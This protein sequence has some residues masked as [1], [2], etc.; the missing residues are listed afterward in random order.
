MKSALLPATML[1]LAACASE[2]D[3]VL[4]LRR[5]VPASELTVAICDVE[6]LDDCEPKSVNHE[7]DV[8]ELGIYLDA[9]IVPPLTV[10]LTATS[11]QACGIVEFEL[12]PDHVIVQFPSENDADLVI[13]GCDGCRLVEC[14]PL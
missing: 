7:G 6:H 5:A 9:P 14:P 2:A 8:T 12:T 11:P 13:S 3:L 10:Q 1:V 4:E